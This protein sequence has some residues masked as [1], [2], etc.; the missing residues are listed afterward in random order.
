MYENREVFANAPLEF[1][2][3]EVRFPYAPQL[4]KE[5]AFGRL[6]DAFRKRF[7]IPEREH[8]PQGVAI[9]PEGMKPVEAHDVY[10]FLNRS[11]T[12]SVTVVPAAVTVE[13]TDYHEYSDFRELLGEVLDAVASFDAVVGVERVGLRYI[14]ELRVPSPIGQPL[15]WSGY[16]NADLLRPL[17]VAEGYH[18]AAV[19]GVIRLDCGE[20][21]GVLIRYASLDGQ[22][23]VGGGP[24][25]RR[26]RPADGPF[27]V[28][29]IDSYWSSEGLDVPDFSAG[30]VLETFDTLH[31]PVGVLF[32]RM[33]TEQFKD[34]VARRAHT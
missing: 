30:S 9:S 11:R 17:V 10:R 7:P 29:D 3:A 26:S 20:A 21:R 28:V 6:A 13:T 16:V 34:E 1:V 31:Q 32:L 25:K 15:D 14:D 12:A 19:E 22:G 2:A 33:V 18:P 8:R 24:L 27:F 5:E 4:S 23:V